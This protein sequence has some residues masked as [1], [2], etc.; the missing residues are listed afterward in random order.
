MERDSRQS[1]HSSSRILTRPID[2][3]VL[4]L[5]QQGDHLLA[6]HRRKAL[7]KL[8]DRLSGVEI[9][10]EGL[11]RHAGTKKTGVPPITSGSRLITGLL[12]EQISVHAYHVVNQPASEMVRPLAA[13][14]MTGPR[15]A[16]ADGQDGSTASLAT[17]A[18]RG[19][20]G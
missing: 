15:A 12:M 14:P 10:D 17:N 7:E 4:C 20:L 18:P 8:I 11:H 16:K 19:A 3:P 1:T 9:F 2:E 6:R 13:G 5:F